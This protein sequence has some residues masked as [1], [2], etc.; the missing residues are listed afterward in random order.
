MRVPFPL[1]WTELSRSEIL[2]DEDMTFENEDVI[3]WENIETFVLLTRHKSFQQA[4]KLAGISAV[5][6]ARRIEKL[7]ESLGVV[8]FLRGKSG[9]MLTEHGSELLE[10]VEP[11]SHRVHETLK[12]AERLGNLSV[13]QR[14]RISATEPV[15][16]EI[17]A[18]NVRTLN[19][20]PQ[21]QIE[22][23]VQNSPANLALNEADI[24]LRFLKPEGDSLRMK[25]LATFRMSVWRQKDSPYGVSQQNFVGYDE[26]YGEIPERQW[27][28]KTGAHLRTRI[29]TSSTHGILN[30]VKSGHAIGILPD[31]IAEKHHDLTRI[32]GLPRVPD[33]PIW[34]MM[35][36]DIARQRSVRAV[37]DWLSATFKSANKTK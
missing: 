14:I 18:P 28:K 26:T 30:I 29:F 11:L 3:M 6:M 12:Q 17:L 24:A 15:I 7:E 34:L 9:V 25:R 4:S 16:S 33:R 10:L 27:M 31:I 37:S 23:R 5:T 20:D 19:L 21:V 1:T 36:P 2:T 8:L 13:R 35:H 22:L 32:E